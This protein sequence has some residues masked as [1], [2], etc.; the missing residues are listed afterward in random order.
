M[1]AGE[2]QPQPVVRNCL[3]GVLALREVCFS[4][5]E[6]LQLLK[7]IGETA[8]SPQMIDSLVTR[9]ADQPSPCIC[10]Q[11]LVRPALDRYGKGLLYRVFREVKITYVANQSGKD[12]SPLLMIDTLNGHQLI[13]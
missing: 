4:G 8:V 7:F 1:A 3:A 13:R 10:R 2:D 5:C 6:S 11:P 12:A 9:C